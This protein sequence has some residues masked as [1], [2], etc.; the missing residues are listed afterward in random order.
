[1]RVLEVRFLILKENCDSTLLKGT[2]MIEIYFTPGTENRNIPG[3]LSSVYCIRDGL[4][5]K[6]RKNRH[7]SFDL[8]E[9][10]KD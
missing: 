3:P 9:W 1:M 2:P 4:K 5:L 6:A 8:I 10:G 7:V